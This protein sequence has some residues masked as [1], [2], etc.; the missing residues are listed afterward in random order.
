MG[1][2]EGK[3]IL[4]GPLCSGQWTLA[5]AGQAEFLGIEQPGIDRFNQLCLEA[6]AGRTVQ[7]LV[8]EKLFLDKCHLDKGILAPTFEGETAPRH[9]HGG[10][11]CAVAA[12]QPL[13]WMLRL[14]REDLMTK[15]WGPG[16]AFLH[17][18]LT[19][20]PFPCPP[21]ALE[22]LIVHQMSRQVTSALRTPLPQ[23]HP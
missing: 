2:S 13:Q 14:F 19:F 21:F 22:S 10:G 11:G 20:G 23:N 6:K 4:Y 7:G 12:V 8:V 1:N 3:N 16:L 5:Q 18:F 17:A 9:R 15:H